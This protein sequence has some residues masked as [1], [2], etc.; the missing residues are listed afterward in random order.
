MSGSTV[1]LL[2][3]VIAAAGSLIF[4]PTFLRGAAYAAAP[5]RVRGLAL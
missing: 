4:T 1:P 3:L 2:L 5:R